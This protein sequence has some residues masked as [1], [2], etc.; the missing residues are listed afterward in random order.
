M[1]ASIDKFKSL[2]SQKG[3]L[4]RSNLFRVVLP[5]LAGVS[6]Q[7]MDVLCTNVNLPGRQIMTQ[8]RLI[9]IKG[10]KMPTGFVQDDV[11]MTFI[12][13]NDY[14]VKKYFE[15]WQQ[16]TVNQDTYEISY[17]ST[18][19]KDIRIDQLKKGYTFELAGIDKLLSNLTGLNVDVDLTV[20]SFAY[21]CVLYDAFPTSLNAIELTND[22][23][24]YVQLNVQLSYRNW[25]AL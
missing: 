25:K 2:L 3:G 24:G 20:E 1:V 13:L 19:A 15:A 5:P 18:Y 4:A 11:S 14:G 8:E 9:G 22:L 21:S 12:V 17:L 10:Q 23:D 7:E 6:S 16:L